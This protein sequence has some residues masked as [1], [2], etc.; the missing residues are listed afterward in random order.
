[1]S[2]L[3]V[4]MNEPVYNEITKNIRKT[5][6]NA[7]IIEVSKIIH[8]EY[9][10]L[11]FLQMFENYVQE[12][13]NTEI[14]Q[15]FHGTSEESVHNIL[16]KGFKKSMNTVSAFGKGT[17]FSNDVKVSKQYA[18]SRASQRQKRDH[19]LIFTI[20]ADVIISS[21]G[22]PHTKPEPSCYVNSMTYPTIFCVTCDDNIIPRYVVSYVENAS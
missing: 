4:S 6:P 12:N 17:Y 16:D 2:L 18:A 14:V 10:E 22:L 21:K 3:Y 8:D 5:Y 9:T 1:M 15:L 20:I 13:E 19:G 11:S 7:C